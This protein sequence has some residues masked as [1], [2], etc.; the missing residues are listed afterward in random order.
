MLSRT[1][2]FTPANASV[3]IGSASACLPGSAPSLPSTLSAGPSRT[4]GSLTSSIRFSAKSRSALFIASRITFHASAAS[5]AASIARARARPPPLR[6][7]EGIRPEHRTTPVV[8]GAPGNVWTDAPARKR[9]RRPWP[10]QCRGEFRKSRVRPLRRAYLRTVKAFPR[11]PLATCLAAFAAG[12]SAVPDSVAAP[13]EMV[14]VPTVQGRPLSQGEELPVTGSGERWLITRL[15]YLLSEPSF[16][17]EMEPGMTSEAIRP[18][19]A[20]PT[21]ARA[22]RSTPPPRADGGPCVFPWACRLH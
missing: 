18:G 14:V 9:F 20:S 5:Q 12:V 4:M 17:G 16:L 15:S 1:S 2:R 22:G 10:G 21:N 19:S 11:F 6:G 3:A 13:F 7:E 8:F